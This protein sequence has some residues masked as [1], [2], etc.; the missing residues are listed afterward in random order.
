[1]WHSCWAVALLLVELV[2]GV[3]VL[4]LLDWDFWKTG[5][6]TFSSMSLL[7]LRPLHLCWGGMLLL[8][9]GWLYLDLFAVRP[10]LNLLPEE[11]V[12]FCSRGGGDGGFRCFCI[13]SIEE[14]NMEFIVSVAVVVVV[15]VVCVLAFAKRQ[16]SIHSSYDHRN[17]WLTQDYQ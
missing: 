11:F 12:G 16:I 2:V 1:M 7:S 6:A 13:T 4:M 14:F 10:I 5:A 3:V 15:V 8:L 9:R 17:I